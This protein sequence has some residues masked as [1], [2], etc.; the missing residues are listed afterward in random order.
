MGSAEAKV[1]PNKG[2]Q[3]YI[4]SYY[5]AELK[6]AKASLACLGRQQGELV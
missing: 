6:A 4:F 3:P 5:E 1:M 2:R